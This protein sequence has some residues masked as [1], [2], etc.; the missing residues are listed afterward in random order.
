MYEKLTK[1]LNFT[2]FLPEKLSQYQNFYYI[3]PKNEKISLILRDFCPKNARNLHKNC[4]KN[5]FPEF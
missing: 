3:C 2:R 1:C 4:P 5:V